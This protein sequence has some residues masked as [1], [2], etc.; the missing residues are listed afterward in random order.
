MKSHSPTQVDL[1]TAT[2][3]LESYE[4]VALEV[5][6]L[7]CGCNEFVAGAVHGSA[8]PPRAR[9]PIPSF[10]TPCSLVFLSV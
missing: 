8:F 9:A 10:Y 4:L 7:D 3:F 6:D 2:D 1:G 5:T